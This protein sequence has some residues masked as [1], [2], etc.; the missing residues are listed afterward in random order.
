MEETKQ[1]ID[2][3]IAEKLERIVFA[4]KEMETAQN[5]AYWSGIISQN[6]FF[7]NDLKRLRET[8]D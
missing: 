6:D 7:I 1:A 3:L 8:L 4:T 2:L 5:K